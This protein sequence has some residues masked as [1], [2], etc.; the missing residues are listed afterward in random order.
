ML[1]YSSLLEKVGKFH[2]VSLNS[3]VFDPCRLQPMSV[4]GGPCPVFLPPRNTQTHS[5]QKMFFSV[6]GFTSSFHS[7]FLWSFPTVPSVVPPK[8][9]PCK[10]SPRVPPLE[11][12]LFPPPLCSVNPPPKEEYRVLS[13][14]ELW[15]TPSLKRDFRNFFFFFSPHTF[16]CEG[17]RRYHGCFTNKLFAPLFPQR[18]RSPLGTMCLASH[19][20]G[21]DRGS[22]PHLPYPFQP[23]ASPPFD[24]F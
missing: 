13:C 17:P 4:T 20:S 8:K 3:L 18:K 24:S 10:F 7:Y 12:F 22:Q 19:D 23:T 2:P 5:Q 9:K 16:L 21:Q 14:L 15:S 11:S 6:A 1:F